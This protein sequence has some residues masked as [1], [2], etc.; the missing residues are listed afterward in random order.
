MKFKELLCECKGKMLPS[1]HERQAAWGKRGTMLIFVL[2]K[3]F[4]KGGTKGRGR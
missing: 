1:L 2:G 4:D 3:P